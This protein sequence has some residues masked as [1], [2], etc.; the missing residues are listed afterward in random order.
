VVSGL[1]NIIVSLGTSPE[2]PEKLRG[3]VYRYLEKDDEAQKVL[4]RKAE[5]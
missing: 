1:I 2:K 3:L 4:R 5:G